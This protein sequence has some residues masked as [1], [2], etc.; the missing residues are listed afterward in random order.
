MT[1]TINWPSRGEKLPAKFN[2]EALR[3]FKD[4]LVHV[5]QYLSMPITNHNHNAVPWFI[6]KS[7]RHIL[8]LQTN[9][10]FH[11]NE[12]LLDLSMH[13][14]VM[15]CAG[16][17]DGIASRL[18]QYH[19]YMRQRFEHMRVIKN[20]GTSQLTRAFG[21]VYTIVLPWMIGPYFTWVYEE[22]HVDT[23]YALALAGFTFLILMGLL[24]LANSL[25]DHPFTAEPTGINRR[26]PGIDIVRLDKEFA[27]T[28]HT[29]EHYFHK[30]LP[31]A[32]EK[33]G[34]RRMLYCS[35]FRGTLHIIC[36]T[37]TVQ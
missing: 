20:Y 37:A 1:F 14:E 11:I 31:S 30:L 19:Q 2:E 26:I 15:R 35:A 8:E 13:T 5:Y 17:P 16:F 36:A 18:E 28:L 27:G 4:L 24:N 7:T 6:A 9:T 23:A 34:N 3:D 32:R 12:I 22:T 21:V 33:M 10:K 25:Q 29:V